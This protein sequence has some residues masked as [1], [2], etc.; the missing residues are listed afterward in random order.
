MRY[1]TSCKT[2]GNYIDQTK[3]E[4]NISKNINIF[5]SKHNKTN[6]FKIHGVYVSIRYVPV[7]LVTIWS[8]SHS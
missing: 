5:T 6:T 3:A 7:A 8:F 4:K 1:L 2:C